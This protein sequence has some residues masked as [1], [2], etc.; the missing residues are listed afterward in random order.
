MNDKFSIT[1][2]RARGLIRIVM[3]G[4]FTLDDVRAFYAARQQAHEELGLP[5]N[6]HLTLNDVRELKILPQ[7]TLA[8]FGEMLADG[9]HHSHR[10]AFV[11][12]PSLVRAQIA[13]ALDG[14]ENA[15]SFEDPAEAEDW[16]LEEEPQ[17]LPFRRASR[18]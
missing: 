14:R 3:A 16:L 10:L 15:R 6:A 2:D 13:R 5:K 1:A 4:L 12:A 8:A 18:G 11:V 7:D 17:A 9:D